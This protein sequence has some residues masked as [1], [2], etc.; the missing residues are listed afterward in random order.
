MSI[1][2]PS[3]YFTYE[4]KNSEKLFFAK[5]NN[6]MLEIFDFL[7]KNPLNKKIPFISLIGFPKDVNE[8]LN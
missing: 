6:I 8:F 5:T 4:N 1:L 7:K 2:A 3:G